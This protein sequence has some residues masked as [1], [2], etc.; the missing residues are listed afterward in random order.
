MTENHVPQSL[1]CLSPE[2]S[3]TPTE[4]AVIDALRGAL[5]AD[6]VD[7][8]EQLAHESKAMGL[9]AGIFASHT[10]VDEV[11]SDPDFGSTFEATEVHTLAVDGSVVASWVRQSVG[12]YESADDDASWRVESGD[13][14]L[15]GTNEALEV[16]L[17]V[18]ELR[19][20]RPEVPE[21]VYVLE[22]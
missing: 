1:G 20:E 5:V 2:F 8:A 4:D 21:P 14:D 12:R 6:D 10:Q 15:E 16:A 22:E 13:R 18:F 19:D 17:V 9:T 7:G 3:L 11:D